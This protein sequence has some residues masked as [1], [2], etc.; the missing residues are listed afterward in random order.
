MNDL[1]D[2][3]HKSFEPL[4]AKGD[5]RVSMAHGHCTIMKRIKHGDGNAWQTVL[6]LDSA[7][8]KALG[9][10]FLGASE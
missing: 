6:I 4:T 2:G 10:L 1:I 5:I 9:A 8:V 7:E 3:L